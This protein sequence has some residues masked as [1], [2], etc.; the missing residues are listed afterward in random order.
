MSQQQPSGQQIKVSFPEGLK[1]GVYSNLMFI[2]HTKEEFI[3]DFMMVSP[4]Q[5]AVT[6]RVI[7]SPGHMKR[8]IVALQDNLKKYEKSYGSLEEAPEPT[9]GKGK[10][11][12]TKS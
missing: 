6:A 9:E 4:P 7:M 10:L 5:G 8:T 12:F 11:G 2:A 1:G 3:L